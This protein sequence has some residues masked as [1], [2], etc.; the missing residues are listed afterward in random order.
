MRPIAPRNL[1]V[2]SS[3]RK[4]AVKAEA[5]APR[6]RAVVR[7]VQKPVVR[8]GARATQPTSARP[9]SARNLGAVPSE[10]KPVID[11]EALVRPTIKKPFIPLWFL[12]DRY[13]A[14]VAAA[15]KAATARA[16]EAGEMTDRMYASALHR[17]PSSAEVLQVKR[18]AERMA[19]EGASMSDIAKYLDEKL[20]ALPEV[21]ALR[22][23]TESLRDVTR[24]LLGRPAQP[25]EVA[26]N[27]EFVR[28]LYMQHKSADEVKAALTAKIQSGA[29]YRKLHAADHVTAQYAAVLQRAPS[30]AEL[31]SGVA[32]VRA[33]I[34]Q[35]VSDADLDA[36]LA[37]G[38]R[39]TMEFSER[40]GTMA[41]LAA[42][43]WQVEAEMP[44][45][46]WCAAAVERSIER[47]MGFPVWGNAN[48]L[49][50]NLPGTGRFQQVNMSLEEALRHPGLILVWERSNG[51]AAGRTYGHTAITTGDGLSSNSD[52][53]EANTLA[54]GA[55][56]EG[57][58]V[59][60][61]IG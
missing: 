39:G 11:V 17:T 41:A 13:E 32:Q 1:G 15:V 58:T 26:E 5:R 22:A 43:S 54:A 55:N 27:R 38:L 28:E 61:P 31:D 34:D 33:L 56:R 36:Q 21:I 51:S 47:V 37:N 12:N 25:R 46:G 40:F 42:K 18:I 9:V 29:E 59:W 35:G 20:D 45:S 60:M 49:D 50:S 10:Q 14:K 16:S 3:T 6:K 48:D 19:V 30:Q 23:G 52:Y 24:E 4:S 7:T 8:A 2:V 44:G 53:H 57:L